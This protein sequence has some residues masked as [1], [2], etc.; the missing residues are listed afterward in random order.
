VNRDEI[1]AQLLKDPKTL[2]TVLITVGWAG[3]FVV[4]IFVPE[5]TL[6]AAFDGIT[7]T[8]VG[9]WFTKHRP[10]GQQQ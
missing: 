8:T 6:G 4:R 7:T 1:R 2:L 5:F 3:S 10:E 9:Y